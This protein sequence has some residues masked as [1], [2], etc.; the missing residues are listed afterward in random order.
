MLSVSFDLRRVP[1]K[2]FGPREPLEV[3]IHGRLAAGGCG[4]S[5]GEAACEED[6]RDV[7]ARRWSASVEVFIRLP[8]V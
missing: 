3:R 1:A 6:E 4:A 2:F 8:C 5:G 7:L